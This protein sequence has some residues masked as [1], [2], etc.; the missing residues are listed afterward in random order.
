MALYSRNLCSSQEKEV[1]GGKE[2]NNITFGIKLANINSTKLLND[3]YM[4]IQ[5]LQKPYDAGTTTIPTIRKL[6]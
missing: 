2:E 5:S 6:I 4:L 1:G 3:N